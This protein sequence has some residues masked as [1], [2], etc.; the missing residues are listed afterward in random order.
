MLYEIASVIQCVGS[1]LNF[2]KFLESRSA[3]HKEWTLTRKCGKKDQNK[4]LK[5]IPVG[6]RIDDEK[7]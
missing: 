4:E 3:F 1:F 6:R 5:E 2:H 7:W